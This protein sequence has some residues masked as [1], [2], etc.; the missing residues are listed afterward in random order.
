MK[1]GANKRALKPIDL[2]ISQYSVLESCQKFQA[3]LLLFIIV[4]LGELFQIEE[5]IYE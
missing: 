4:C 2:Q 5:K 3:L 1:C